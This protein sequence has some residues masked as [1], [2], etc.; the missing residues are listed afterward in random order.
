MYLEFW[1]VKNII[2]LYFIFE[3]KMLK[4]VL[5]ELGD[6]LIEYEKGFLCNVF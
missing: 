5:N 3:C 6:C 4:M 2:C 1:I